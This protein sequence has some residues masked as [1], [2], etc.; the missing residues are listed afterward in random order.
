MWR[1][2]SN[3]CIRTQLQH[4]KNGSNELRIFLIFKKINSRFS[5]SACQ[6]YFNE[7]KI[8]FHPKKKEISI[9][10]IWKKRG[11]SEDGGDRGYFG[12]ILFLFCS[13][14]NCAILSNRI[15]FLSLENIYFIPFVA[16][17]LE[18]KIIWTYGSAPSFIFIF[19]LSSFEVNIFKIKKEETET[20]KNPN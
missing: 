20:T 7:T 18:T 9:D 8:T 14:Y 1:K 4:K 15:V 5:S 6:I 13:F 11:A 16:R 10:I 17:S 2:K 19:I 12:S 3:F